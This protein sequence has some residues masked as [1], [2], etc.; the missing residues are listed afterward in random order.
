MHGDFFLLGE[1]NLQPGDQAGR[2][3]F[4]RPYEKKLGDYFGRTDL[5]DAHALSVFAERSDLDEARKITSWMRQKSVVRVT[6]T[7]D[8][9]HL[10]NTPTDAGESHHDWWTNPHDLV[11]VGVAVEAGRR[12]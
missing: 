8:D 10:K 9:G 4:Q 2:M 11:P 3:T 7:V 12:D 1:K 5:V 6:V